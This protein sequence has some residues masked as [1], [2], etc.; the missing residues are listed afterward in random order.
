MKSS[1]HIPKEEVEKLVEKFVTLISSIFDSVDAIAQV[2]TEQENEWSPKTINS[3]HFRLT[4]RK[5]RAQ[6]IAEMRET[7]K[8]RQENLP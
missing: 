8:R 5:L 1:D 7:E 4:L 6:I 2:N 3:P